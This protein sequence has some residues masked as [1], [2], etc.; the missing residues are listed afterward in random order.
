L[1]SGWKQTEK[2]QRSNEL[3]IIVLCDFRKKQKSM[4]SNLI[5]VRTFDNFVVGEA[6]R[7][8]FNAA[9]TFALS[10][11][12]GRNPLYI[13]GATGTGKTHLLQ[14]IEIIVRSLPMRVWYRTTEDLV[15][16]IIVAYRSDT[17]AAFKSEMETVDSL[18]I[19]DIHFL[20]GKER[21]QQ[22]FVQLFEDMSAH[23]KQIV[24]TSDCPPDKLKNM[25]IRLVDWLSRGRCEC[26]NK[27]D[28]DTKVSMVQLKARE[29]R[30]ELLDDVASYIASTCSTVREIEG[31]LNRL[32]A[33]LIFR[34]TSLNLISVR[35]LLEAYTS[36]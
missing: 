13:F 22:E 4:N 34:G 24:V 16:S 5:P 26:L 3:Q 2:E 12:V 15:N 20:S 31:V 23:L 18:L 33:E 28:Q 32:I 21:T 11:P 29:K 19:D 8:G 30:I 35:S 27:A 14:A 10:P 1:S 17:M 6:N 9:Y 36:V 25:N 7:A